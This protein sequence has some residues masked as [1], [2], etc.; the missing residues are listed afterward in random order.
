[1]GPDVMR[2]K[3][4]STLKGNGRHVSGQLAM[5]FRPSMCVVP[6]A[7]R[8]CRKDRRPA[9][10]AEGVLYDGKNRGVDDFPAGKS[11]LRAAGNAYVFEASAMSRQIVVRA[12]APIASGCGMQRRGHFLRLSWCFVAR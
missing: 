5:W 11:L 12:A 4:G 7:L 6:H 2:R 8:N 10:G 1:M 9:K 3:D